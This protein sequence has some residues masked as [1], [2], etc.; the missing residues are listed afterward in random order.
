MP[1]FHCPGPLHTGDLI[2]LPGG[3]TRHVQVLRL[4]P[5]MALTLFDGD[6]GDRE[7]EA[8]VTRMGRSDVQVEIGEEHRVSREAARAI[9]LAV[10]MPA[11]ER[12]DW[13]VEKAVE[14]GAASIQPLIT[15][16]SVLRMA[17]D[18]AAKK[19]A[20]WQA[21][22]VAACEQCGRNRVPPVHAVLLLPEWLRLGRDAGQTWM[23]SLREGSVALGSQ[24]ASDQPVTFLSGPEGGLTAEEENAAQ[25]AGFQAVSLGPRI[26]RAETAAL[27]ALSAMTSLN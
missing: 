17:G 23:L 16:R 2:D 21:I 4:Q 9:H 18:R 19:V 27:A 1:R 3:A 8:I 22:A 20:H 13:L 26:L 15:S 11:N 7:F 12:M 25:A 5:G 6:A 14:L 24:P 10:G